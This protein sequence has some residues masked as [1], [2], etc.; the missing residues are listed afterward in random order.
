MQQQLG[1]TRFF[2]RLP[3]N[4]W[5]LVPVVALAYPSSLTGTAEAGR[6]N[7]GLKGIYFPSLFD[8]LTIVQVCDVKPGSIT[9]AGL[10][11]IQKID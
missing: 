10:K 9:A 11:Y 7:R 6:S 2:T 4:M 8:L 3:E 1:V 5:L